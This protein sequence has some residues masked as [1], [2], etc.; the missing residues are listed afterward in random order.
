MENKDRP[1]STFDTAFLRYLEFNLIELV[2]SIKPH[3]NDD[4]NDEEIY[5]MAHRVLEEMRNSIAQP[6]GIPKQTSN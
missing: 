6:S 1:L 2:K 4:V 5:D 3:L